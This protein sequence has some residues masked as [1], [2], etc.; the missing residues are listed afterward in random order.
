MS[1]NTLTFCFGY[2]SLRGPWL[3][4]QPRL[5]VDKVHEFSVELLYE[6]HPRVK[7]NCVPSPAET[8]IVQ[9]TDKIEFAKFYMSI[10]R[11]GQNLT[12]GYSFWGRFSLGELQQL[13]VLLLGYSGIGEPWSDNGVSN[14][15]RRE[16]LGC[17]IG[18]LFERVSRVIP[19]ENCRGLSCNVVVCGEVSL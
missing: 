13:D 6:P 12:A 8:G 1:R 5:R 3:A 11:G 10:Y 9:Q 14:L 2:R 7:S 15:Q 19:K 16:G 17:A 18:L 4:W